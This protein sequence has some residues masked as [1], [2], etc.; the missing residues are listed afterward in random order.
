MMYCDCKIGPG[1]PITPQILQ[2]HW[3]HTFQAMIVWDLIQ[4]VE[5]GQRST[6][7]LMQ[8]RIVYMEELGKIFPE[9]AITTDT[10]DF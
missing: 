5:K 6:P 8:A 9:T 10:D 4:D 7:E 2:E 1:L 3:K